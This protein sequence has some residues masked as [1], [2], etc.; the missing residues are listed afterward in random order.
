MCLAKG[1]AGMRKA[2]GRKRW[3][4]TWSHN[5]GGGQLKEYSP[6]SSQR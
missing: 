2:R 5:V 3:R 1:D 6:T 4:R